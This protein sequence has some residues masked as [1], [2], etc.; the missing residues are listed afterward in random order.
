MKTAVHVIVLLALSAVFSFS[1]ADSAAD[2]AAINA[3]GNANGVAL[4]C[5]LQ[6][7]AARL[8][9]LMIGHVPKTRA[10]GEVFEQATNAAFLR[11][12]QGLACPSATD[13]QARV[14]TLENRLVAHFKP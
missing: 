2:D 4:A 14:D 6:E 7:S 9:T 8:K 10:N 11:Q 1:R 3:L 12:H 13:M 5:K